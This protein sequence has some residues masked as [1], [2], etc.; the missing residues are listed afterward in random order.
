MRNVFGFWPAIKSA[1]TPIDV[2]IM[3]RV[4]AVGNVL[5]PLFYLLS[6]VDTNNR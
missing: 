3:D 5:R 6:S 4:V 1:S 2:I